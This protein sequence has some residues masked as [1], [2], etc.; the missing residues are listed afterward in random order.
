MAENLLLYTIAEVATILKITE[1]TVYNYIK[2]GSLKAA[3]IGKH[4]RVKDS[5]LKTF[6]NEAIITNLTKN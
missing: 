5:D 3:K 4:W 2:A 6:V 1:R